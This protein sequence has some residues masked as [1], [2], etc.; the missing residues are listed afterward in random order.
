MHTIGL[1][2]DNEPTKD[3]KDASKK[4]QVMARKG[5]DRES[6]D[7]E[8]LTRL[9]K[10]LTTEVSEL[11]QWKTDTFTRSYLPRQRQ[12]R[13]SSGINWSA[14]ENVWSSVFN[15]DQCT[16]PKLCSFHEEHHPENFCSDWKQVENSIYSHTLNVESDMQKQLDDKDY[17]KGIAFVEAL[18][19]GHVVNPYQCLQVALKT[20]AEKHPP[21]Q[22]DHYNIRSK[23]APPCSCRN[24]REGQTT[25]NEV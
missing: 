4:S 1:I 18:S 25:D 8:T 5:R 7:I 13:N 12:G 23:G 19:S 3:S 16:D 6:K 22:N 14:Q 2:K 20:N 9:V 21:R 11:K 15:V 24:E 17:D 10:N